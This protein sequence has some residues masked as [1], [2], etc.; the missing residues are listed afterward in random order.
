MKVLK[1]SRC[2]TRGIFKEQ[3]LVSAE[4]KQAVKREQ[5]DIDRKII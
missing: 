3:E 1:L 5:Q 2:E 4:R